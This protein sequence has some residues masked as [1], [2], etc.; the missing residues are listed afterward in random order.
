MKKLLLAATALA[1]ATLGDTTARAALAIDQN[2]PV[3]TAYMAAFDQGD[4]AQSFT[5]GQANVAGAGIF[6]EPD[7]GTGAA[8]ITIALWTALPTLPGAIQ[9][10]SASGTANAP[11]AWF[12]LFW[13]PVAVTPGATYILTFGGG[14]DYGISGDVNNGYPGGQTYAN[15]GFSSFP[16]FDYAFR[17]YHDT[18]FA[19]VPEPAA[20]ALFGLGLLALAGITRRRTEG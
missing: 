2:A 16:T 8:A 11:G 17:T 12:D 18:T 9:L 6:L 4:L 1:A 20:M 14:G 3:N 15:A 10:A 5:P 19:A 13:S 7:V